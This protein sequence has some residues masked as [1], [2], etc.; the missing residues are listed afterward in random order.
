V[1]SRDGGDAFRGCVLD[2]VVRDLG[3]AWLGGVSG[4]RATHQE[5]AGAQERRTREPMVAEAAHLRITQQ[6]VPTHARN[7]QSADVLAATGRACTR[8]VHVRAADAE[9]A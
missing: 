1:G 8:S 3:R 2:S 4:E 6:L 5:P 7:P 9:S